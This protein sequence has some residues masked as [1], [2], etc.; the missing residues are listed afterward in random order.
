MLHLSIYGQDILYGISK[1]TFEIPFK[2]FSLYIEKC[3]FYSQ[4]KITE[5][6]EIKAHKCF[7]TAPR[8]QQST[9]KHN[10]VIG[11][12]R[13]SVSTVNRNF[14]LSGLT[15]VTPFRKYGK[16]STGSS[17]YGPRVRTYTKLF[18]CKSVLTVC[19]Y[20]AQSNEFCTYG[21]V[22]RGSLPRVRRYDLL[23]LRPVE[24]DQCVF[25][26]ESLPPP[27][28]SCGD[29]PLELFA[30]ETYTRARCNLEC[31]AL[32]LHEHCGCILH[33][34]P[35]ISRHVFAVFYVRHMENFMLGMQE[36]VFMQSIWQCFTLGM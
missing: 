22:S 11:R 35:G 21:R 16:H 18:S 26:S 28:G 12:I 4:V 8:S 1:G 17:T 10:L 24:Y 34:M 7:E 31:Q 9:T 30:N 6:L 2:I 13:L 32:A 25:Q 14:E 20:R 27:Y 23:Y 36:N 33:H 3:W 5:L 29:T 19:S 15:Q